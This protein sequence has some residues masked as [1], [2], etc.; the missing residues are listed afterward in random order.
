MI[1]RGREEKREKKIE[2]E[3]NEISLIKIK[4]IGRVRRRECSAFF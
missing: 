3:R 1:T 2:K 4:H